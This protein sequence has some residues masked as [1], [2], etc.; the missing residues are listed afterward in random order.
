MCHAAALADLLCHRI[1]QG[2][3]LLFSRFFFAA[4]YLRQT[5]KGFPEASQ[6]F[7][8]HFPHLGI[9]V[10]CRVCLPQSPSPCQYL[11]RQKQKHQSTGS[12]PKKL[13]LIFKYR[14]AVKTEQHR[15]HPESQPSEQP[16]NIFQASSQQS[17]QS[18]HR[19]QGQ[20]PN[21]AS[22]KQKSHKCTC[23][24]TA[25]NTFPP[26]GNEQKQRRQHR[27]EPVL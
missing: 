24:R 1:H 23:R 15:R 22:K 4:E 21:A 12:Q 6:A 26:C 13:F 20:I 10:F 11:F 17:T 3:N 8:R 19:K 7:L 16:S 2:G 9:P 14:L 25:A 18:Q 27:K 5:M